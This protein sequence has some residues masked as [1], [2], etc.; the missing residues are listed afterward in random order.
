MTK[1]SES[2]QAKNVLTANELAERFRELGRLFEKHTSHSD[3]PLSALKGYVDEDLPWQAGSYLCEAFDLGILDSRSPQSDSIGCD[4]RYLSP[5]W[6]KDR[7]KAKGLPPLKPRPKVNPNVVLDGETAEGV[8]SRAEQCESLPQDALI[9]MDKEVRVDSWRRYI[10][11]RLAA[12]DRTRIRLGITL[13]DQMPF[14]KLLDGKLE[15]PEPNMFCPDKRFPGDTPEEKARYRLRTSARIQEVSCER[16]AEM[17][18]SYP[19]IPGADS[20]IFDEVDH[21][22]TPKTKCP[23]PTERRDIYAYGPV[24]GYIKDLSEWLGMSEEALRN[25]NDNGSYMVCKVHRRKYECWFKE[26]KKYAEI[27]IKY[28]AAQ[29]SKPPKHS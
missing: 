12:D 14:L 22:P 20:E 9:R 17:L 15:K 4:L 11:T 10:T 13:D 5:L 6:C 24:T 29:S 28:L 21:S 3:E 18:D 23:W 7:L 26:T 1:H 25:N 27:N 16:L 19:E 2:I 8:Q